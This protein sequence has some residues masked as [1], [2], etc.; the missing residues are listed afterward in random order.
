VTDTTLDPVKPS[1][2]IIPRLLAARQA[3]LTMDKNPD[4]IRF[5]GSPW[6][7]AVLH[8]AFFAALL[9]VGLDLSFG[10]VGI[11]IAGLT[12]C[13]LAP[14]KRRLFI[15]ASTLVF[16]AVRPFQSIE[17]AAIPAEVIARFDITGISPKLFGLAATALFM[18]VAWLALATQQRFATAP[19]P[20]GRC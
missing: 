2:A 16:L 5:A 19:P 8:L 11:A 13:A 17:L 18:V 3:W 10:T 12:G 1:L 9:L 15:A 7:I 4:A 14:S 6:G 20:G